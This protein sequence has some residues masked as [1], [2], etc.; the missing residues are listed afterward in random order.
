MEATRNI[1]R[2]KSKLLFNK[3]VTIARKILSISVPTFRVLTFDYCLLL[4]RHHFCLWFNIY[5]NFAYLE[6]RDSDIHLFGIVSYHSIKSVARREM[7]RDTFVELNSFVDPSSSTSEKIASSKRGSSDT[8]SSD[9][10]SKKGGKRRKNVDHE[11][12]VESVAIQDVKK[13]RTYMNR[14]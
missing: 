14:E 13:P 9:D 10:V 6:N 12:L 1:F 4:M 7:M 5:L 11:F 8:I 2:Q 3:C